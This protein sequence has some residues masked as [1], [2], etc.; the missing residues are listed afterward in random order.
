M[1]SY[2]SLLEETLGIS[3][4]YPLDESIFLNKQRLDTII[5]D[6]LKSYS[7]N[8]IK[9]KANKKL[10]LK[11]KN[12]K[13]ERNI[14][15]GII[16]FDKTAENIKYFQSIISKIISDIK[17]E[18]FRDPKVTKDGNIKIELNRADSNRISSKAKKD[19]MDI[20]STSVGAATKIATGG[21]L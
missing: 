5:K 19:S 6:I 17:V 13:L 15:T 21:I 4:V 9:T 10:K 12:S 16:D 3:G 7:D 18:G 2:E 20:A 14:F 8:G 1:A 11:L